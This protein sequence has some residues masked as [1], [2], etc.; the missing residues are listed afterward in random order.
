EL[1][2]GVVIEGAL[3]L[4]I[5]VAGRGG[6]GVRAGAELAEAPGLG[7]E[8][9]ARGA[10]SGQHLVEPADRVL[11]G[12]V[13]VAAVGVVDDPVDQVVPGPQPRHE[14]VVHP[15]RRGLVVHHPD[16]VGD[17]GGTEAVLHV[18]PHGDVLGR[19]A[20]GRGRVQVAAAAGVTGDVVLRLPPDGHEDLARGDR[21]DAPR[22]VVDLP[23]DRGVAAVGQGEG[24]RRLPVDVDVGAGPTG[25]L[26]FVGV[27]RQVAERVAAGCAV[28]VAEDVQPVP[29]QLLEVVELGDPRVRRPRVAV[30]GGPEPG[31]AR[32]D[33]DGAGGAVL[34][35]LRL[36]AAAVPGQQVGAK[37][38]EA[39]GDDDDDRGERD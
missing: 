6:A 21:L 11:P 13:R 38:A 29:D 15:G 7:L 25:Y 16:D 18:P 12:R 32:V 24:G 28:V 37:G 4:E 26:A 35:G 5:E 3:R 8:V 10:H 23:V 14:A 9:N 27:E 39:A 30:G 22:H 19:G 33:Q 36:V 2:V 17:T 20:A 31:T 34:G 1:G